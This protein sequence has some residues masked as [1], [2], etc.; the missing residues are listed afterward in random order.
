MSH[1]IYEY[2]CQP[3]FAYGHRTDLR[4][5]VGP[6]ASWIGDCLGIPG[7]V[8]Y[9]LLVKKCQLRRVVVKS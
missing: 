3:F 9:V 5:S 4:G 7:A 8:G 2:D 1:V 6:V